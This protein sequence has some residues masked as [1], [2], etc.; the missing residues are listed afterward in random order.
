MLPHGE[1]SRLSWSL[2]EIRA[3]VMHI[4]GVQVNISPLIA[5]WALT[6]YFEFHLNLADISTYQ[7]FSRRKILR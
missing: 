1:G 5:T 4:S 7:T 6:T 2:S 3:F